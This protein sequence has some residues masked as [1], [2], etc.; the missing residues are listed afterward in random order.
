MRSWER[1]CLPPLPIQGSNPILARDSSLILHTKLSLI[2]GSE[3]SNTFHTYEMPVFYQLGS[4][5]QSILSWGQI[6]LWYDKRDHRFWLVSKDQPILAARAWEKRGRS[7]KSHPP[8]LFGNVIFCQLIQTNMHLSWFPAQR[9]PLYK[10]CK[11]ANICLGIHAR[12]IQ[13][14]G[15]ASRI[16]LISTNL[17]TLDRYLWLQQLSLFSNFVTSQTQSAILW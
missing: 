15:V 10:F 12:A 16:D 9:Y 6:Y 14:T 7:F 3:W 11:R 4:L 1:I 13:K 17:P 5:T 2:R 8:H